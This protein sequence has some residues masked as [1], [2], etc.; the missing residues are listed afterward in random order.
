M[1]YYKIININP[2]L[3]VDDNGKDCVEVFKTIKD[4]QNYE[5]SNLGRVKSISRFIF[6]G[7]SGFVSKEK[8]LKQC[9]NSGGY[10]IVGLTNEFNKQRIPIH[11]LVS[12]SFLNNKSKGFDI[13]VDHIDNNKT[14][15]NVKN[16]QLITHRAN[17]SKVVRGLSNHIG[18]NWNKASKKWR[19]AIRINGKVKHLGY[20]A[21]EIEASKAYQ[22][23]LKN[24]L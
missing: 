17:V 18:V 16:L 9:I 7:N 1:E 2:I 3:Y 12:E 19:A 15:N 11:V 14:N 6:N 21:E 5:I 13:V 8:I 23:E 4:Y 20:F 22:Q 24:I 10:L